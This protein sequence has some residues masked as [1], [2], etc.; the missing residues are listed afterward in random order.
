MS[1]GVEDARGS[2]LVNRAASPITNRSR[3]GSRATPRIVRPAAIL[4]ALLAFAPVS[5][6][7]QSGPAGDFTAPDTVSLARGPFSTMSMR[8][9]KT[10]LHL[11]VL[12]L[13]LRLDLETAERLRRLAAGRSYSENLADSIARTVVDVRDAWAR[14]RFARSVG[15]GQF[16]DGILGN[17]RKAWKAGIIERSDYNHMKKNLRRWFAFLRRRG[18]RKGDQLLYRVRSGSLRTIFMTADGRVLL[19]Q[20]DRGRSPPRILMGSYF[21]PDSDFRRPLIESLFASAGRRVSRLPSGRAAVGG[22]PFDQ[23]SGARTVTCS[24]TARMAGAE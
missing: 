22:A 23:G 19:D 21:A 2:E 16:L 6:H 14:I 24:A 9:D 12:S 10:P 17:V 15:L 8:L 18:I 1:W 4:A 11:N 3:A 20:T 13:R 5:V 7:A